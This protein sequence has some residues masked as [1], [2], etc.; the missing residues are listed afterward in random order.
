MEP[1]T[2]YAIIALVV[3]CASEII[4]LSPL[5][6]NSIIQVVIEVLKLVFPKKSNTDI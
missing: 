1:A 5:K 4:A 2:I 3:A 6:S